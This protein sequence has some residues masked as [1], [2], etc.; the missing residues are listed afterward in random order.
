MPESD[1]VTTATLPLSWGSMSVCRL[2]VAVG[3]AGRMPVAR[4]GKEILR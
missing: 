2:L 1:P 4:H 3:A